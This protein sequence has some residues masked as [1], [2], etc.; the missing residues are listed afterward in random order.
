MALHVQELA[1]DLFTGHIPRF[2]HDRAPPINPSRALRGAVK[3]PHMERCA[4]PVVQR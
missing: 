1:L 4:P 3:E 2:D